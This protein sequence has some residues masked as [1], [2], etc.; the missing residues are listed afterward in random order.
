VLV[1]GL[2]EWVFFP[3]GAAALADGDAAAYFGAGAGAPRPR[4]TLLQGPGDWVFVPAGWGHAVLN[5]ADS[6]AIAWQ[7]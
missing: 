5:L 2:K 4:M 3:P 1:L 6:A 7:A